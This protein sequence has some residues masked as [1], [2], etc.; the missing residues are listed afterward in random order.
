MEEEEEKDD[1]D[2]DDTI[3]EK[4]AK[5]TGWISFMNYSPE[6]KRV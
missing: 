1:N 2:D 4:E 5:A 3:Y 6:K